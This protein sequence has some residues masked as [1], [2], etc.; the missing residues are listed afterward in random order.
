MDVGTGNLRMLYHGL[1]ERQLC[2]LHTLNAA[3][4]DLFFSE[5]DLLQIATYLDAR[6]LEVISRAGAVG[7]GDFLNSGDFNVEASQSNRELEIVFIFH[8]QDHCF[9]IWNVDGEWYNFNSLYSVHLSFFFL[10]A[11]LDTMSGP[12]S[13]IYVVRGTFPKDCP[14]DY[15]D[16]GQWLTPNEARTITHSG[17]K[18]RQKEESITTIAMPLALGT[19]EVPGTKTEVP[20]QQPCQQKGIDHNLKAAITISLM[21]FETPATSSHPT[22]EEGISTTMAR[23]SSGNYEG[24]V[25]ED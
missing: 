22:Q 16:F 5:R 19:F 8:F 7:A 12:R 10:S 9:Y 11:Y 13:N 25:E 2:G 1:H 21:P 23:T 14:T 20:S 4:Q 17:F 6:K 18:A 24:L 3:L 15:N